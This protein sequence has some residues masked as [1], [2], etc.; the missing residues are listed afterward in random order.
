MYFFLLIGC[1]KY[2]DGSNMFTIETE[3]FNKCDVSSDQCEEEKIISAP[4][5]VT[6]NQCSIQWER[7]EFLNYSQW[8]YLSESVLD[9]KP[10]HLVKRNSKTITLKVRRKKIE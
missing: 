8:N 10:F 7:T 6:N 4:I 5:E 2:S 3:A 9:I 1:Y